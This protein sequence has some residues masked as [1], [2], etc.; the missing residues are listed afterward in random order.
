M[1]AWVVLLGIGCK[2]ES[3]PEELPFI[4]GPPEA[5]LDLSAEAQKGDDGITRAILMWTDASLTE[6]GFKI[7]RNIDEAGFTFLAN[8]GPNATSFDDTEYDP[9]KSYKY[10]VKSFNN[11]G[12]ANS[13][14]NEIRI[15][16]APKQLNLKLNITNANEISLD[17]KNA[18]DAGDQLIVL[19][20]QRAL[21]DGA[22]AT[23]YGDL[24]AGNQ[25]YGDQTAESGLSYR[26]RVRSCQKTGT[27]RGCSS[28]TNEVSNEGFP[29]AP[30]AAIGSYVGTPPSGYFAI[31]WL[32]DGIPSDIKGFAI[33]IRSAGL[34]E[35]VSYYPASAS[36]TSK[37]L[38]TNLPS[39]NYDLTIR[40]FKELEDGSKLFSD[41]TSRITVPAGSVP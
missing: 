10:R 19:E 15:P 35:P 11:A 28:P 6:G 4:A 22:W 30:T 13:Y 9:A 26:Y 23:I 29:V 31:S 25:S 8:A 36:V 2:K 34:P 21:S 32:F 33:Y 12:E 7:E 3:P 5:A 41:A 27:L 14:T 1:V 17:W 38:Y 18:H 24:S 16:Q 20:V 39:G 40:A 37:N